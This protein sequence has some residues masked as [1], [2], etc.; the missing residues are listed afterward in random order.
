MAVVLIT[1]DI[2]VVAG[3]A[4]RIVVMYAGRVIEEGP[5]RAV[6]RDPQH[7]YTWSLLG[8]I[9]RL[10]RPRPRRLTAIPGAPPTASGPATGCAFAPRCPHRFARCDEL[11]PLAPRRAPGHLDACHL[12]V[13][14]RPVPAIGRGMSEVLLR[15][16][17]VHKHFPVRSDGLLRREVGSV[18]AVDGVDLE[19]LAGRDAR[20]RGRVRAAASRRSRGVLLRL[21]DLTAGTVEFDGRDISTLGR[22]AL[23]PIRARHPDDLPGPVRVAE[24]AQADRREHRAAD[25][26]PQGAPA[27][28]IPA[29][30]RELLELVGLAPEHASRYP[31]EFSGGQRQRIGIA[32]AL[33]LRPKLVVADEPVS[34]LDVSIQAQIINLLEDLQEELG[35]TYVFIAHDLSV[36]RQVSDRIAVMYLGKVVEVGPAEALCEAPVHPY[37]EALLSAVPV[38]DPDVARRERIV[39]Q[40]D[41][42]SPADP[43]AGCRFHTRCRYATD[44]CRDDRAAARR[45]PRRPRRGVPPPAGRRAV[46]AIV[47][48]A[49]VF[50]AAT[51]DALAA[52]GWDVTVVEQYA[53]GN[54]RGSSGDR[55]RLL[56]LGHGEFGEAEDL[57]YIRSAARGIEL[58]RALDAESGGGLIAPTGLV[59]LAAGD[60]DPEDLVARPDGRGGRAVRAAHAGRD[61]GAVPR[62]GR[63]R[64]RLLGLRAR[65]VRD[66]RGRR[67]RRAAAPLRRA[68]GARPRGAGRARA[69]S[70][71]RTARQRADCVVWCCGPWLGALF[72]ALAP[73]RP[74]WQDV[75]HWGAP[76]AWRDGPA[77]IDMRAGLYGF[78]DVDGLGVKAVTHRPG[79]TLDLERD[80]RVPDAS[81]AAEVAGY[82]GRRFPALAGAPLLSGRVMPYE[83]TPDGHFL[84]GPADAGGHWL[85][86]GGS[87]HGFKHAPAL[88]EHVA[89]LVEGRAEVVP[90][91]RPGPR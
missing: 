36:V 55:T 91:W 74:S 16:T 49:G 37:T 70:A 58:W 46:K 73:V 11:P 21:T 51:A 80:A 79:R 82:L 42:P 86:G 44:V 76:P 65:R 66:P 39:L 24:P 31:H 32:R 57:H 10:D 28:E 30:V 71:C 35:T 84:A 89:D 1:H 72:P 45:A 2:G 22:G 17:G 25:A 85:L 69:P 3:I 43:P 34:A 54:A 83:L 33:A 75:L 15:A 56:R 61:G 59:W 90:M 8:S 26:D 64:P 68:P 27:A 63:R 41:V 48:G 78:P 12:P 19:V 81:V 7:P 47:V 6:F 60:G 88:G 38:P 20:P 67:R 13:E 40:G 23:R 18:R 4:D 62:H 53:P 52:R 14:D 9:P 77:W 87:G 29:Q 5:T 50:G